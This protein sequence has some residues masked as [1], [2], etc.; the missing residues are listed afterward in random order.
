MFKI[1][2]VSKKTGVS[3]RSLRHY[4]NIGLLSPSGVSDA[5]YR[6][7]SEYDIFMLQQVIMLKKM[8]IP[9]QKIKSILQDDALELRGI[10]AMQKEYLQMQM[11]LYQKLFIDI[12]QM[13][14]MLNNTNAISLELIYKTMEK[15]NMLNKYYTVDQMKTLTG[16]DFHQDPN[17]GKE[18][19]SSWQD[20][21]DG[22]SN[23][24]NQGVSPES[25]ATKKYALK[26][27]KLVGDFVSGDAGIEQSLNKMYENEGG[28]SMLRSHGL[29]VS[30]TLFAYYEAA[31]VAHTKR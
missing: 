20:V 4:D 15:T 11:N 22:L 19:V 5:G 2:Y 18:Y 31:V 3:V 21:F 13:L 27:R 9:L 26:S 25:E 23:L 24:Q 7:Y 12:D 30:D 29:D 8:Q 1:G 16:R 28:A 14:K 10:L 17:K 6:L